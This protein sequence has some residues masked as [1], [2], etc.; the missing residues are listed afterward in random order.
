[1]CVWMG[2]DGLVD[3]SPYRW[4]D[5]MDRKI[6]RMSCMDR[7][8]DEPYCVSY[9][10]ETDRHVRSV[11]WYLNLCV[12]CPP[13][14]LADNEWAEIY[15]YVCKYIHVYMNRPINIHPSIHPRTW[16]LNLRTSILSE[17]H[18]E[19]LG[20]TGSPSR[21][22]T[23]SATSSTWPVCGADGSQIHECG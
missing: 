12:G 8:I 1:M 2:A 15:T 3:N 14:G 6:I 17:V 10:G 23:V 22:S 18:P 11:Y 5:K 13:Q 21:L 20:G 4:T 19:G 7:L 9:T 16:H